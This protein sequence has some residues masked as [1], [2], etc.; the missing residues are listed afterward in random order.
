M[1]QYMDVHTQMKGI[2]KQQLEEAHRADA[3][4]EKAEKVHF[5]KAWADPKSGRVFCLSEAP[6]R[7]AVQRVHER[8]GH[9][10]DEIYEVPL[11]VE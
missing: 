9:K 6:N 3:K 8:A 10:A 11:T 5:I 7:E 1:P 4:L 2:T